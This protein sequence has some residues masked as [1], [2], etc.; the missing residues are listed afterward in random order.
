VNVPKEARYQSSDLGVGGSNPS[1][2]AAHIWPPAPAAPSEVVDVALAAALYDRTIQ[3]A[4]V[5]R[6]PSH[7]AT[8]QGQR[9]VDAK[10]AGDSALSVGVDAAACTGRR[11]T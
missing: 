7:G 11:Y 6:V 5:G 9:S 3:L 4:V 1:R 8:G 2:C 10:G